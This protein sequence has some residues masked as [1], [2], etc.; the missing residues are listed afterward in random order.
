MKTERGNILF[1]ILL[2]VILFAALSYAVTS[3]MR[4]GGKD[5]SEESLQLAASDMLQWLASLDAAVMR[6][7]LGGGYAYE[8]ISFRYERLNYDGGTVPAAFN[9]S[10]CTTNTCRI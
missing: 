6:M 9:N 2:A 8:D 7:H 3:S 10:R 1:L 5:A 4:G